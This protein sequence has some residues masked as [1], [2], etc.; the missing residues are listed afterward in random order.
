MLMLLSMGVWGLFYFPHDS[1]GF[2]YNKFELSTDKNCYKINDSIK[3]MVRITAKKNGGL[4][5]IYK[6]KSNLQLEVTKADDSSN[7]K[8][9]VGFNHEKYVKGSTLNYNKWKRYDLI[10]DQFIT[11]ELNGIVKEIDD[12]VYFDFGIN[13]KVH[14]PVYNKY[15]LKVVLKEIFPYNY[16]PTQDLDYYG[17]FTNSIGITL[18]Q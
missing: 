9:E 7:H 8:E 18:L 12:I 15:Q 5:R 14:C 13:G 11:I 17:P 10:K 6:D 4:I 16:L 2:Y 1:A 3:L